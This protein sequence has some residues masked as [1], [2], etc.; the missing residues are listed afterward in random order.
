MA[1]GFGTGGATN[2]M[3]RSKRRGEVNKENGKADRAEVGRPKNWYSENP[4]PTLKINNFSI[5]FLGAGARV[6]SPRPSSGC[7]PTHPWRYTSNVC[8]W[9]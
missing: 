6:G 1:L 2:A 4:F 7:V 8:F 5:D 9:G 3:P